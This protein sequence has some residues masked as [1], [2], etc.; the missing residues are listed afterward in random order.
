[1]IWGLPF[2]YF[3]G[4]AIICPSKKFLDIECFG[5]GLSRAF[6][7]IIHGLFAEAWE[8][9]KLSFIL[10]PIAIIIWFHVLGLV[11]KKPIFTFLKSYY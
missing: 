2:R 10:F 7:R 6:E 3:D 11:I 4:G 1:M 5:C 9:N 8:L